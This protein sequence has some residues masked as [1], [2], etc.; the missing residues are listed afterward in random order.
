MTARTLT[1]TARD[2][3]QLR[4]GMTVG[5]H[6]SDGSVVCVSMRDRPGDGGLRL[7]LTAEDLE[8][9]A[10]LEGLHCGAVDGGTGWL[11]R[12]EALEGSR[13]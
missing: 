7:T 10:E 3:G 2:L 4:D 8:V 9:V 5:V 11:V 1:L 13:G 12:V 6:D